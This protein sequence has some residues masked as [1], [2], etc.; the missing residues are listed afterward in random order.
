MVQLPP[1]EKSGNDEVGATSDLGKGKESSPMGRFVR[2]AKRL[3]D[4]TREELAEQ[5][6]LYEDQKRANS[7]R[8]G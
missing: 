8:Q 5:E 3:S 7:D 2:L 4:V 6:G 1:H